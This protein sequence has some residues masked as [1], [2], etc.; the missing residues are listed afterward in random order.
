MMND[1]IKNGFD[2]I[3]QLEKDT[4]TISAKTATTMFLINVISFPLMFSFA[5]FLPACRFSSSVIIV[6]PAHLNRFKVSAFVSK[7]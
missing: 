2:S 7:I 3:P 1:K 5:G 6:I 4:Q